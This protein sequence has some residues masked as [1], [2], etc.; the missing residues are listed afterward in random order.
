MSQRTT[1]A[2]SSK[3]KELLEINA[4]ISA[5]EDELKNLTTK[6]ILERVIAKCKDPAIG[7]MVQVA[8]DR[9][10]NEIADGVEADRRA[11]SVVVSGLPESTESLPSVRQKFDEERVSEMLDAL[12]VQCRPCDVH[13]LGKYDISRPR[14]LKIL[15]PSRSHWSAV[16]ANSHKL[17][18]CGFQNIYVRRSMTTT[19]RQREF[20]LRQEA[21]ARNRDLGS[22]Q[23]VIYRGEL[24]RVSELSAST[25]AKSSGN[26]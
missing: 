7:K 26:L 18:S 21:R 13:R 3:K 20:E 4:D 2:S 15:L 23:W 11:R 24:R 5:I 12:G 16:L 17:R 8:V 14:L 10:P 1:R 19:E 22:K 25:N 9:L 6:E